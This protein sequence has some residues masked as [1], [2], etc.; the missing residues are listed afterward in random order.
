MT[1]TTKPQ[2]L[3]VRLERI[4]AALKPY[5]R[6][7][8]WRWKFNPNKS[9]HHNGWD[10]PPI[11]SKTGQ[12][13]SS[14]D[15]ATWATYDQAVAYMSRESMDGIGFSLLGLENIVVHDLDGCRNP[16]TGEI[17][18]QAMNI[19]RLVGSYWEVSPSGLGYGAS[20]GG[21]KQGAG[22]RPVRVAPLTVLNTMVLKVAIS[23][24][25]ATLCQSLRLTSVKL[26][27][28]ASKPP[29]H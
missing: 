4:P 17:T 21:R 3:P 27:L 15:S 1:Q 2:T 28:A 16:V 24:S 6:F 13:A 22:L 11:N 9:G 29:M 10:E 7:L 20:A 26:T 8:V 19:V 14:T 5:T 12:L 25:Q 23:P 18:P